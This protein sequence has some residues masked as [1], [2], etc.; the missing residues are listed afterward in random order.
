MLGRTGKYLTFSQN[1]TTLSKYWRKSNIKLFTIVS[2]PVYWG[3]EA[4]SSFNQKMSNKSVLTNAGKG[5]PGL[6]A[7]ARTWKGEIMAAGIQNRDS[8]MDVE[9][10]EAMNFGIKMGIDTAANN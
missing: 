8:H 9:Y 10:A 6:A 7:I 2:F 5:M 3:I 1:Y 4:K